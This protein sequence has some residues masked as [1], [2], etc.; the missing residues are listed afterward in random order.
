MLEDGEQQYP[1]QR[2]SPPVQHEKKPSLQDGTSHSQV[3][4][5]CSL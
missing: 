2:S 3:A 1:W 5:L 4:K